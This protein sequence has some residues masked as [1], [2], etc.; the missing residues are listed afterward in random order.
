M[1]RFSDNFF[2]EIAISTFVANFRREKKTFY[3]F[4]QTIRNRFS[5]ESCAQ[6]AHSLKMANFERNS[7]E[8]KIIR[9]VYGTSLQLY[10]LNQC[11]QMVYF[12]HT[13]IPIWEN[14]GGP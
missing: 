3:V 10:T 13:N 14:F 1:S 6:S 7:E 12:H 9:T 11:C 2:G 4:L 5:T 8:V